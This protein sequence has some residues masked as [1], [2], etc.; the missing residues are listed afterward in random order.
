MLAVAWRVFVPRFTNGMPK[1]N[2]AAVV[3]V[4]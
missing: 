1:V 2:S 3:T 4:A